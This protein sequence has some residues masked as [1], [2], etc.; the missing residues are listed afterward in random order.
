MKRRMTQPRK[1]ELED[2]NDQLIADALG[3]FNETVS[4]LGSSYHEL[5]R[6][7]EEL[8]VQISAKNQ[9]LEENLYEVNRLRWFFDSILNSMTNGVVVIDREGK[10]V[11]FNR[12]AEELTGFRRDELLGRAYGDVFGKQV[13][14]RFSPLHTLAQGES[15]ILEE[16]EIPVKTGGTIPIRYSTSLVTDHQDRT[17]GAVEVFSDL[18][19]IKR[20]ECQMQQMKTQHAL[21]QMA[22][23]V[24]HEIRN[25]LGGIRGYIDL[26]AD[27]LDEDDAR[28]EMIGIINDS[29]SRLDEIVADFQQFARP[30]KPH[31]EKTEFRAF[32][33]DVIDYFCKTADCESKSIRFVMNESS[34]SGSVYV[35]MD[36][37]LIEQAFLAIFDNAVKAMKMGGGTV[38][39]EIKEE[40]SLQKKE[41]PKVHILVSDS[42]EGIPKEVLNQL[43]TPFFTTREKGAGLGLALAHNFISNHQGDIFVESEKGIGTTVT[44]VL[45]VN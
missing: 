29:I 2:K 8:N 20:L 41:K 7:I 33:R 14:P 18:T 31:F 26:L 23:L 17:L 36:P 21:N 10:I 35:W 22:A 15:L 5:K 3:S 11:L 9:Q 43:F 4:N 42:G 24:A 1:E 28:Q 13:S 25:P 27:S 44:V 37:I 39:V 45:P 30:V 38:R 32:L 34:V 40:A 12:G 16:K 19:R 6:R